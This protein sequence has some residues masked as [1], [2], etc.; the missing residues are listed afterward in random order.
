MNEAFT[1]ANIATPTGLH[2][3]DTHYSIWGN[4]LMEK[5]SADL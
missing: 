1:L 3:T 4:I 5:N 2:D